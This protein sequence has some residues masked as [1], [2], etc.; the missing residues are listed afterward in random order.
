MKNFYLLRHEDVHARSGVGIVAEGTIFDNGMVAMT[1]L[2]KWD[3]VTMFKNIRAVRDL[4]GH[5]GRTEI[6]VGGRRGQA[7][8]DKFSQCQVLAQ[9]KKT[10]LRIER[11]RA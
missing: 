3:T 11:G 2:S 7:H 10:M 1:W 8:V 5:D 4:H 9:E 6:V